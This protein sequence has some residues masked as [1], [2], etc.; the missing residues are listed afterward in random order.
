[1]SR[2][3][4]KHELFAT[5]LADGLDQTAAYIKAGF[6][7]R[8][9]SARAAASR[10][11]NTKPSI[12]NRRDELLAERDRMKAEAIAKASATV[13]AKFQLDRE[14]VLEKMHRIYEMGT[15]A[16]PVLDNEGTPIGEYRTSLA[17]AVQALRLLGHELHGLFAEKEKGQGAKASLLD[18]MTPEELRAFRDQLAAVAGAL[19][20]S[21][22]K[23]TPS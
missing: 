19:G 21:P 7:A 12:V 3:T 18:G 11:V 17:P 15:S 20:P 23:G 9:K 10:L 6:A 5:Y 1:M 8:G 4:A 16:I 14:A 13:V 22:G 2:H